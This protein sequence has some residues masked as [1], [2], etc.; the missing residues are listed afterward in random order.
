[1]GFFNQSLEQLDLGL[2][3]QS[4]EHVDLPPGLRKLSLSTKK[5]LQ[6]VGLQSPSVDWRQR[7]QQLDLPAGRQWPRLSRTSLFNGAR[8][9]DGQ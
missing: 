2:S 7:L 5:A 1:M 4:L 8:S 3:N 6:P 9:R